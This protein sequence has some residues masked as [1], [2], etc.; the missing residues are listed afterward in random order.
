MVLD[1]CTVTYDD[2][3]EHLFGDDA[4]ATC[5]RLEIVID[6]GTRKKLLREIAEVVRLAGGKLARDMSDDYSEDRNFAR[7]PAFDAAKPEAP[8]PA[9]LA[10]RKTMA[11]LFLG[12][13]RYNADKRAASTI[14]RYTPSVE[15]FVAHLGDTDV[16]LVTEDDV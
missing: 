13:T 11:A 8:A 10:G 9:V 7:F 5:A 2:A 1:T 12:W 14:R 4:D 3:L 6:D 16:C 15:S